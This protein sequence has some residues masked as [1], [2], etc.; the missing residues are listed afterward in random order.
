VRFNRVKAISGENE[1]FVLHIMGNRHRNA[2]GGWMWGLFRYKTVVE[3]HKKAATRATRRKR[4]WAAYD[5]TGRSA[6]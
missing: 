6:D 1:E 5:G 4:H 3:R 2:V